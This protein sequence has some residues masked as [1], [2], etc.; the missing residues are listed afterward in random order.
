MQDKSALR[1]V[2]AGTPDFAAS[3]LE[4][5]IHG[6]HEIV[7]VYTQPDRPAGRGKRLTASPVK[8]LA[9]EHSLPVF[10]PHNL[11]DAAVQQELAALE[12]DV[13]VVVAYGLIL[14][15]SVLDIP[16]FGCLNIHASLLPRWRGAAPIQRAIEA[17]DAET[18]IAV[19]QMDAGL[20]TGPIL[21]ERR[22]PILPEDTSATLFESLSQLGREPLLQVLADL[23]SFQAQAQ[24]QDES[25]ATYAHKISTGEARLD[26]GRPATELERQIRAFNPFPAAWAELGELRIKI[27]GADLL[28]EESPAAPGTI[29]HVS[30]EGITVQCGQGSLRLSLLQ[31]PG[32]RAMSVKDILLGNRQLFANAG[33]F[34][35]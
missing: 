34:S 31:L 27:F 20:D 9:T 12:P 26:W 23:E 8:Q 6:G 35:L 5:L 33:H 17:G 25:G 16:R 14:P 1:V 29:T 10:Q 19:M 7:A 21:M 13:M 2:F 15:Q 4:A 30:D 11:K 18:G 32:K 22:C 28:E 3:Y 24:P